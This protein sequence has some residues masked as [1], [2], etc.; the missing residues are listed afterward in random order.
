MY[1][2]KGLSLQIK[3]AGPNNLSAVQVTLEQSSRQFVPVTD[4]NFL[5]HR[6]GLPGKENA[7]S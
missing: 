3:V 5:A 2:L 1:I 6:A 4:V 7:V